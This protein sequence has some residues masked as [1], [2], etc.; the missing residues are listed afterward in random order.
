[1]NKKDIV[2][3]L[4]KVLSTHKEAQEAVDRVF[5]EMVRALRD[6]EK[7]VISELGTFHP[8]ITKSRRCRNPK[9]GET[10]QM[11]PRRKVRFRQSTDL[12]EL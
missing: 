9:T 7:L 6:G 10:I 8:Y 3:S 12:F 4:T 2:E 1:M 11:I 5:K